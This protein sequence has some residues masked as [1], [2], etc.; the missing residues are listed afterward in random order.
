MLDAGANVG[1]GDDNDAITGC[2]DGRTLSSKASYISQADS[3]VSLL[4]PSML[5]SPRAEMPKDVLMKLPCNGLEGLEDL[6]RPETRGAD[7]TRIPV[8]IL[9][10][11]IFTLTL[12]V[13]LEKLSSALTQVCGQWRAIAL[14]LPSLWTSIT[15]SHALLEREIPLLTLQL[16]RSG[17]ALLNVAISVDR[18]APDRPLEA[19]IPILMRHSARR[20]KLCIPGQASPDH[21][22]TCPTSVRWCWAVTEPQIYY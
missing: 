6:V 13:K 16:K 4:L 12:P 15:V 14:A 11:Y 9:R 22:T 20:E 19:F 5:L 7:L 3:H 10:L 21:I 17:D 2:N 8:E 18:A 1:D